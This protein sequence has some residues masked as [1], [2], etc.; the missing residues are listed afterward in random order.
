MSDPSRR[1]V[2]LLFEEI[3]PKAVERLTAKAEVRLATSLA[4]EALLHQVA[5][6]D[7]IIIRANGKVDR[8]LMEAAPRLKVV[9][10]HGTGVEAIDLEAAVERSIAIVNTPLANVESVAE[11]ALGMMI[12][13]AKRLP[14]ADRAIR[15]GDWDARYR[16]TGRELAGKTLGLVGMGRIGGRLA[17]LAHGAFAMRLLYRDIQPYP[18]YEA[19]L[20]AERVELDQLLVESD[21][22]SVH[23]PL[24]PETHSLIGEA[25]LRSM[26]STAFLLNT[27]RGA[28]VD[29]QA[30][31]QALTEGWIA[32]AGLDVFEPEPLPP[33]HPLLALEN[34]ILSPH[35]AAHTDEALLRM[36][37]VADDILAVLD[38]REPTH[39]V[40]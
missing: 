3:H 25:E 17:E 32:G 18:D 7:G 20:K 15:A 26:R 29:S 21:V 10:R 34:V 24:L 38:G 13:L 11:H 39:R 8:R 23:V 12:A 28:V 2:V 4:P 31:L 30:L 6:V 5:D 22:V 33:D 40:A 16:L 27:A 37:L 35:M 9:G 36:A 14:E 19:R 1:P